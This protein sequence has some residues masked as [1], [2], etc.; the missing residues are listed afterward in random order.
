MDRHPQFYW[1]QLKC[2]ARAVGW[3]FFFVV[4]ACMRRKQEP[5]GHPDVG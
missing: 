4:I 5:L 3:D 1:M 2:Q